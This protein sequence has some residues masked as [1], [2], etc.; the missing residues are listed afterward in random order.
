MVYAQMCRKAGIDSYIVTG[1]YLGE[2]WSWNM[3]ESDGNFYHVDLLRSNETGGFVLQADAQM[4]DYVWDYSAYPVCAVVP[5]ELPEM[6]ETE[7][8]EK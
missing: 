2:R 6:T 5:Q 3:V 8:A 4:E 7:D 1:T